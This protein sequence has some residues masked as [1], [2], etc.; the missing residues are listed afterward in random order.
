MSKPKL[1]KF[2]NL[3]TLEGL[4]S[5]RHQ[6]VSAVLADWGVND[7]ESLVACLKREGLAIT[8]EDV[9]RFAPKPVVSLTVAPVE[10][11]RA[12]VVENV[13][14]SKKTF[15]EAQFESKKPAK[16]KLTSDVV[17]PRSDDPAP[18]KPADVVSSE[19]SKL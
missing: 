10:D 9:A 5:R 6:S 12:D 13:E 7:V 16:A 14:T 18:T 4:A 2:Q 19:T 3:P 8:A 17:E 15:R 1:P 11:A